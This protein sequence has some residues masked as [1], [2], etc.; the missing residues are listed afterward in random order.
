MLGLGDIALPGLLGVFTRRFDLANPGNK[1]PTSHTV[2]AHG[3]Q[4]GYF[5]VFVTGY[6]VGIVVTFVVLFVFKAAQ[7]A[8]LYLVPGTLG[9]VL[10]TGGSYVACCNT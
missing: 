8:L 5:P 3:H 7:P 6:T 10:I 4:V 1:V 2:I 9:S